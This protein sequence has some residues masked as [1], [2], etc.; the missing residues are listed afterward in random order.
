MDCVEKDVKHEDAKDIV[1]DSHCLLIL[2][3]ENGDFLMEGA[4]DNQD[5]HRDEDIEHD[6]QA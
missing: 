2:S 5:D 6:R 4:Q 3:E 1:D